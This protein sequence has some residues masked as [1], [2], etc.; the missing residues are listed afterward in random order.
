MFIRNLKS[1]LLRGFVDAGDGIE[2]SGIT[3]IRQ[4]LGNHPDQEFLIIAQI[5]I[6]FGVGGKLRFAAAL[7]GEKAEGD[8]LTLL[9]VKPCAGV[10]VAEAVGGK[11][12]VDMPGL[13]GLVHMS[14]EDIHL[15]LYAFFPAGSPA[16]WLPVLPA[17][18]QHP[19]K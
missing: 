12:A 11:P 14:A 15:C 16:W 18:A 13:P 5:H 8:H 10:V 1:L 2:T 4:T 3:D 19:G 7:G 9:Q 6:A 17:E